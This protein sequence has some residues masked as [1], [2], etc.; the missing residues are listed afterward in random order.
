MTLRTFLKVNNTW[1]GPSTDV[2]KCLLP[3]CVALAEA[4]ASSLPVSSIQGLNSCASLL[5]QEGSVVSQQS[6]TLY[7]TERLYWKAEGRWVPKNSKLPVIYLEP[8]VAHRTKSLPQNLFHRSE[9][10][11]ACKKSSSTNSLKLCDCVSIRSSFQGPE[12]NFFKVVKTTTSFLFREPLE[13]GENRSKIPCSL[14]RSRY[15]V[16]VC[17]DVFFNYAYTGSMLSLYR[18]KFRI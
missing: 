18:Y 4:G 5:P 3:F 15:I 16:C 6:L 14:T 12:C 2:F 8:T 9:I 10:N 1:Q 13:V 17:V 11:S 7:I